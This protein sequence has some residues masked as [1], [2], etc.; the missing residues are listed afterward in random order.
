MSGP[1]LREA[2]TK[3]MKSIIY[4]TE[5]L[6]DHEVRISGIPVIEDLHERKKIVM[7][8]IARSLTDPAQKVW[9]VEKSGR[10]LGIFIAGIEERFTVE[11]HNPVCVFSHAYNQKTVL[12]IHEIH[13][14]MKEW[15]R[16]KGCKAIQMSGLIENIKIQ[17][18][19]EKLGYTKKAITYEMEV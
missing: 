17:E 8:M 11:A 1:I 7:E 13:N 4:L 2:E 12:P 10:I 6:V 5:K 15:A 16:E 14:R 3:D 9:V 18:L 19:V